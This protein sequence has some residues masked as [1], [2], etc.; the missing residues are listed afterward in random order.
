MNRI[1]RKN[2]INDE[3]IIAV[4]FIGIIFSS[5]FFT[6]FTNYKLIKDEIK[7]IWNQEEVNYYEKI[8]QIT[9]KSES[10]LNEAIYNKT[11]YINTYGLV[12]RILQKKYIEDNND[13]SREI[14]KTK[15]GML[16]FIQKEEKMKERAS[17]ILDFQESLKE[18]KI[19]VIYVQ[20]PYKIKKENDLPIGVTDYANKNADKLL[21]YLNNEKI[22][23]ID[24]R[25]NFE[26][27]SVQEEYFVTD[28]HWRITTAFTAVN[29]I[30]E[31]LNNKYDFNV[32]QY[33]SD[34][35]NYKIIKQNRSFLGSIGKRIGRYYSNIDDF[36][37]ILPD[38]ETNF[39][40]EKGDEVKKGS[41][42]KTIVI[43]ELIESKDINTNRYA[44]YFGGDFS[45]IIVKNNNIINNKKVLV[46]QDSYGLAFS[47][48]LSLRVKEL[49]TIDL[50]HFDKQKI[51]YAKEY[52][53]DIVII[54]YNPSSFY[55]EKNFI[56]E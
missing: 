12:Q 14:Y 3:E 53:P 24:L 22:D 50:R 23:T 32:N 18:E 37:Y 28:H 38:F 41:F 27:M 48:L 17:S 40:V 34:I 44:C 8:S 19:P 6:I 36:E 31:I 5:L 52:K 47:A 55:I 1:K 10:I 42:E 21:E 29:Y 33:Y 43:K 11:N 2:K 46:I 49:R 4:V 7:K 9:N 39:E 16:T 13:K 20:A 51:A 15:D 25:K 26:E 30:A 45:E 35:N 56:L 54:L